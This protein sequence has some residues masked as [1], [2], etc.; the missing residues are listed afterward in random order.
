MVRAVLDSNIWV[1]GLIGSSGSPFEVIEAWRRGEVTVLV[2][3]AIIGEVVEVLSRP[4]FRRRRAIRPADVRAIEALLR[5]TGRFVCPHAPLQIVRD[6]P[7]DDRVLECAA[8]GGADY[9]LS[10]DHHLLSLGR[11][12]HAMIVTAAQFLAVLRAPMDPA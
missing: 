12:G 11:Y 5:S 4:F 1:S 6:D 9:V 2:S 7:D 8:E 10:G 3:D